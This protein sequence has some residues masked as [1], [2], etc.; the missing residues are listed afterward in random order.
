MSNKKGRLFLILGASGSGKGTV[1]SYLRENHPEFIFPVS[2]TTREM[3]PGE[4]EGEVYNFVSK[5]AFEQKISEGEFLEWALVHNQNYYGTLKAPIL[6]AL[7]EGKTVIREVDIQG[8]KSIREILNKDQ[9]RSLF[10]TVKDWE[11]LK[12]RI[13]HRSFMS[14]E[15][16]SERKKSYEI[17]KSWADECDFVV[18]SVT[19]DIAGVCKKVEQIIL[20]NLHD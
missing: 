13:L 10:L 19:G 1:L 14:E 3:R 20:E 16:L 18:E 7:K 11:T 8:L 17:E 2:C 12:E 6:N 15:E 5:S 4:K 9:L